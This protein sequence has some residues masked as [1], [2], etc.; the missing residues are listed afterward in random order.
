[1]YEISFGGWYSTSAYIPVDDIMPFKFILNSHIIQV[2]K[3]N[4]L[5][6]SRSGTYSIGSATPL[7]MS[8]FC[9]NWFGR[10]L[11]EYSAT[12]GTRCGAFKI[13]QDGVLVRDFIPVRIGTTGALYDKVDK[14]VHYN[15]LAGE[16]ILGP[17]K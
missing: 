5:L 17:D 2:Y 6:F 1:M 7:S 13:Y 12:V 10:P 9:T 8:I 14:N 15:L 16:F 3:N 11:K 4:K